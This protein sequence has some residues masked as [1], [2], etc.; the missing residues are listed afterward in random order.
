MAIYVD[1]WGQRPKNLDEWEAMFGNIY[2]R[3][4]SDV[5]RSALG[6]MEELGELAEAIRVY[7][8]HPHYFAGEAADIFSYIMGLKRTFNTARA[9]R[10]SIFF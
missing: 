5:T 9:R 8:V 1:H 2:P 6:L 10:S 4:V 7:D 3:G